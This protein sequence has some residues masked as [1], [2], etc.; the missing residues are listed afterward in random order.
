MTV[1]ATNLG[2][3]DKIV[4]AADELERAGTSPFTAEDLVVKAWSL[5]PDTFGLKG[6]V[7]NNGVPLYPDSNRVFAEIMGSK[8]IRKMGLLEKTGRKLYALTESGK[9]RSSALRSGTA[10]PSHDL[11]ASTRSSLDRSVEQ[12]LHRLLK[13][14]AVR[15]VRDGV[16]DDLTFFDACVF[17]GVSPSSTAIQLR[18]RI[19]N[20]ESVISLGC[21]ATLASPLKTSFGELRQPDMAAIESAHGELLSRFSEEITRIEKR[22]DERL[23][24]GESRKG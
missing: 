20:T 22:D 19:A 9:S 6:H 16:H 15:K 21:Q 5:F 8:P 13:T 10:A 11:E 1:D 12:L 2:V 18:G 3:R 4:L 7:D 23:R 24:K 17:W 14:R